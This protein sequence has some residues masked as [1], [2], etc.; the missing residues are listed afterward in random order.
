VSP[1]SL[2][3]VMSSGFLPG[4][5]VRISADGTPLVTITPATSGNINYGFTPA[6]K[7]LGT[8]RHTLSIDSMLLTQSKTFTVTP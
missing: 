3:N 6:S 1:T 8:G 4:H 5:P 7:N 2:L